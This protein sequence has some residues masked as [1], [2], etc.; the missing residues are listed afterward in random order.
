MVSAVNGEEVRADTAA[1]LSRKSS[2]T[3]AQLTSSSF[4]LTSAVLRPLLL[5]LCITGES[6]VLRYGRKTRHLL[7]RDRRWLLDEMIAKWK[8]RRGDCS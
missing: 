5:T 1:T 8:V 7:E 4:G 6:A 3:T 2:L